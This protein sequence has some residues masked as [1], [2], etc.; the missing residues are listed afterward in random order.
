VQLEGLGNWSHRESN[1][2]DTGYRGKYIQRAISSLQFSR[3]CKVL[4]VIRM[5]E[6]IAPCQ[7][8]VEYIITKVHEIKTFRGRSTRICALKGKVEVAKV[9]IFMQSDI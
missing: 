4:Y 6:P 5:N 1:P 7:L 3:N 9:H 2:R 8:G